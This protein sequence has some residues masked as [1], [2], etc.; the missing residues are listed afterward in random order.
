LTTDTLSVTPSDTQSSATT[1]V[2][3]VSIQYTLTCGTT[4]QTHTNT[5]YCDFAAGAV[6]CPTDTGKPLGTKLL[7]TP[8]V[9]QDYTRFYS[10]QLWGSGNRAAPTTLAAAQTYD[11]NAL[12]DTNLVDAT[13]CPTNATAGACASASGNGWFVTHNQTVTIGT[14]TQARTA[15]DEK[16]GSAALI[17]A[18]CALWNT[19]LPN[20]QAVL[21]CN[22]ILPADNAFVYQGDA[23]T[24]HL[25]C[26]VAGSATAKATVRAVRRDTN[27]TPQQF[28]P[29]VSLNQKTGDVA[30][31]GVSLEPGA[32]P[33][34]V[35]VG[36]NNVIG[37]VKWLEVS[38]AT[39]DCRH[40]GK[41]P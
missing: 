37:F 39:H 30:Y 6:E 4:T 24:G 32:P 9:A 12:T 26:G 25:Q 38:R 8:T 20:N 3:D 17:L 13:S 22:G 41:C 23:L 2:D 33:L 31:S 27:V 16:T 11:S 15:G 10:V 5:I 19:L 14:T 7:W 29:V 34:Q 35:Q 1:D 21:T 18:G 28:T 36:G 40:S